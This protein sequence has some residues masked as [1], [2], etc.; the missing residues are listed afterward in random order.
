MKDDGRL[1]EV[2]TLGGLLWEMETPLMGGDVVRF[3]L[4]LN[5]SNKN[6]PGN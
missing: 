4:S 2:E 3:L 6:N 5:Y 1:K